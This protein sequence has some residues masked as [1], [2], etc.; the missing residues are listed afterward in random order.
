MKDDQDRRRERTD[1]RI[2]MEFNIF[3][4]GIAEMVDN[5]LFCISN[6]DEPSE[7]HVGINLHAGPF[8]LHPKIAN[9]THRT[10]VRP[11]WETIKTM[12]VV[13]FET[14][15][16]KGPEKVVLEQQRP[17]G[18]IWDLFGRLLWWRVSAIRWVFTMQFPLQ[19]RLLDVDFEWRHSRGIKIRRLRGADGWMLW[20]KRTPDEMRKMVNDGDELVALVSRGARSDLGTRFEFA[21]SAARGDWG[22]RFSVVALMSGIGVVLA[23]KKSLGDCVDALEMTARR[24][25][26]LMRAALAEKQARDARDW[27]DTMELME[28]RKAEELSR[29]RSSQFDRVRTWREQQA[30]NKSGSSGTPRLDQGISGVRG[31][32]W[33]PSNTRRPATTPR[34]L[35]TTTRNTA[36]TSGRRTASNRSRRYEQESDRIV[37]SQG[38]P[39]ID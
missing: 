17:T 11:G 12:E 15:G 19:D 5:P 21:N 32:T 1:R 13:L 38:A 39:Q 27:L 24:R 4:S 16:M 3:D 33:L 36:L 30:S 7:N 20:R 37:R 35:S 2:P 18:G 31:E 34:P 14:Q 9:L 29:P 22:D 23:E 8:D 26:M 6:D 10:V 28:E 25:S